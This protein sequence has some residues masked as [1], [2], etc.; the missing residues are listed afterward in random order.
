[1][2]RKQGVTSGFC[3]NPKESVILNRAAKVIRKIIF[4]Y[5]T[6]IPFQLSPEDTNEK[7][8]QIPNLS[9]NHLTWI[10]SDLPDYVASGPVSQVN[11]Q[12]RVRISSTG[13]PKKSDRDLNL[14]N[15]RNI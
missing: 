10:L 7:K 4:D 14:N 13:C 12:L 3:H 15:S 9:Y 11:P 2:F 6:E 8:I 1:M 5:R